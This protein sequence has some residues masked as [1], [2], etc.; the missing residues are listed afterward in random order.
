MNA[1]RLIIWKISGRGRLFRDLRLCLSNANKAT[2]Q[3]E[4][5][6]EKKLQRMNNTS[7]NFLIG[8]D[9]NYVYNKNSSEIFRDE[10]TITQK[11]NMIK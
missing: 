4:F 7:F 8:A 6:I 2:I 11:Q 1:S 5:F 10:H 3:T 9:I